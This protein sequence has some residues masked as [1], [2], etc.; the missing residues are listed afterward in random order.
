MNVLEQKEKDQ[1]ETPDIGLP[2]GKL[3]EYIEG[4]YRFKEATGVVDPRKDGLEV[5]K[6]A[7]YYLCD[8]CREFHKTLD[9]CPFKP[10]EKK[11]KG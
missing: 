6:T 9:Q 8:L 5:M 7:G 10:D 2:E 4:L 3:K 1:T 11:E